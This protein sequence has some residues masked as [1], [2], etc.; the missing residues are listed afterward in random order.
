MYRQCR[1]G[2]TLYY[3]GARWDKTER[4]STEELV[5]LCQEGYKEFG[6]VPRGCTL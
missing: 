3:D 5:G 6:S 1:L 4:S 2:E